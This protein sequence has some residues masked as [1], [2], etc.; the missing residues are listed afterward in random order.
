MATTEAIYQDLRERI[1]LLHYPPGT[2]LS[3]GTLAEEFGV[4]RTPIRRVLQR[5]EFEELVT[6]SRGSGTI[7]TTVDLKSLKEV[8]A[9]RLKLIELTGELAA[10]RVPAN[11]IEKLE[12]LASEVTAMG[13]QYDPRELGRLYNRFHDLM[14]AV[15]GNR[16]LRQFSDQLFHQTARVWLQIL[17]DLDWDEEVQMVVEE[18]N[19]VVEGLR[20]GDMQ[21]VAQARHKHMRLMLGRL[22]DYLGSALIG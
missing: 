18:I 13:D 12:A 9:L 10:S 21:Q 16:A 6:I 20:A 19:E 17:P 5:L 22:N 4:S 3:E 2:A 15:I 8:Y 11:H 7:V 14:L 1:C